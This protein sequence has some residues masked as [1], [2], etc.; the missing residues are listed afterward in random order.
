MYSKIIFF[1]IAAVGLL[2][3]CS[4]ALYLPT[5]S[6]TERSGVSNEDLNKGRAL[7]I[8]RCGSC[9]NLHL[10]EQY[11]QAKWMKEMPVME[12][13]AKISTEETKLITHYLLARCKP[14]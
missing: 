11:S 12:K 5:V 8:N 6:D 13:K 10:P 3:A 1:S 2:V 14:E 7:Y 9:H 4:S